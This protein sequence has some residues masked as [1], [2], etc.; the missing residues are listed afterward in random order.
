MYTYLRF[1]HSV[2]LLVKDIQETVL[3]LYIN[4]S[5]YLQSEWMVSCLCL[6]MVRMS[7]SKE[8]GTAN[9]SHPCPY[10]K[11]KVS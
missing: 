11:K 3:H 8:S 1:C 9:Y 4:T 5:L 6:E 2:R 7:E 10:G